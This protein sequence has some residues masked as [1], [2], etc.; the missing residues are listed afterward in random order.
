VE[1]KKHWGKEPEGKEGQEGNKA[2]HGVDL[3][4]TIMGH[5]ECGCVWSEDV[6]K[7]GGGTI[8][9]APA[10]NELEFSVEDG[11]SSATS[12]T[13]LG[14]AAALASQIALISWT[15]RAG[16]TNVVMCWVHDTHGNSK[17]AWE[18]PGKLLPIEGS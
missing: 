15:L 3:P 18:C 2:M 1:I 8:T 16:K 6:W 14:A 5:V 4:V 7:M 12:K 10:K 13:Q 11:V 9:S 17:A